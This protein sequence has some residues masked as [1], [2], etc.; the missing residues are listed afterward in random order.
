LS[1][2]S[3]VL[4]F[5]WGL[6]S[7]GL[8]GWGL[9]SWGALGCNAMLGIE[10]GHLVQ[11]AGATPLES[12]VPTE[13]AV[14]EDAESGDCPEPALQC[15]EC[16][17][18][19]ASNALALCL[20]D[21]ACRDQL[22]AQRDC[23]FAKADCS[24]PD[25]DCMETIDQDKGVGREMYDCLVACAKPCPAPYFATNCDVY[26][27]AM[28]QNCAEASGWDDVEDCQAF[29]RD[30]GPRYLQCITVHAEVAGGYKNSNHC[31]HAL[32]KPDAD[33]CSKV[34]SLPTCRDGLRVTGY[35][36]T[37]DSQC[38]SDSCVGQICE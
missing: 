18:D 31:L 23:L 11:E 34:E 25:G 35:A 8:L 29:C 37:K 21:G 10:P 16:V 13:Q 15:S 2:R 32:G 38:C 20:G 30:K 33:P 24:D 6:L 12:H 19:C 22:V 3:S 27:G 14:A 36:C 17:Q 9:L 26:C 5:G 1:S 7:S 28:Q 4:L